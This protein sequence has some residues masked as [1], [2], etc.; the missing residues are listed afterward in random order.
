MIFKWK[1]FKGSYTVGDKVIKEGTHRI[2]VHIPRAGPLNLELVH[3]A[4]DEVKEFFE[5]R[6]NQKGL[7]YSCSSWTLAPSLNEILPPTSN[8]LKFAHEYTVVKTKIDLTGKGAGHFIFGDGVDMANV[9]ALPEDSTL[10]RGIKAR[11][12]AGKGIESAL[13]VMFPKE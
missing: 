4:Y 10:R 11:L 6:Y 2:E 3:A 5:A 9:D 1:P 13:G 12:K 7:I 8:I